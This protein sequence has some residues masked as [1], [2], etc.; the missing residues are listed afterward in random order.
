MAQ[1]RSKQ[2][3]VAKLMTC[4]AL[5][6]V[7]IASL[8]AGCSAAGD[9]SE[10]EVLDRQTEAQIIIDCTRYN[11]PCATYKWSGTKCEPTP[12]L[13]EGAACG[14]TR[15]Y[16]TRGECYFN[17]CCNGCVTFEGKGTPGLCRGDGGVNNGACGALATVCQD[18]TSDACQIPKC[19]GKSCNL[20][21]VDEGGACMGSTGFC[22]RGSCCRG[23][24][25]AEGACAPGN[26]LTACGIAGSE[27]IKCSDCS[28]DKPCTADA[29]VNGK[30]QAP[31]VPPQTSCDDGNICNGTSECS[32]T[33]C[34][35]GTALDCDD[36]DPCTVDTCDPQGGCKHTIEAGLDCND[37]DAC[38]T[39]EKCNAAGAC[40]GGVVNKCDDNKSC[41]TD[42]CEA[43]LCTHT[44]V[45]PG[46]T[47][48][49]GNGCTTT[50]A[51]NDDGECIGTGGPTCDDDNQCTKNACAA[52]ICS[53]PFEPVTTA[54]ISANKCVQ[55]SHCAGTSGTCV[56]G[57]PLDC[58]DDNDCTDD[59]CDPASGCQHVPTT[60]VVECV[61][62]NAC[63]VMDKC[64]A[65]ECVGTPM[66]CLA[67]DACHEPGECE[68]STGRCDDPRSEDGKECPGGAC[69]AG[70][71]DPDATVS[72]GGA[73]S[74]GAAH[75]E[76]GA[77]SGGV[78]IGTGGQPTGDAGEATTP[79]DGGTS[80]EPVERPFVRNPGGC[81][82]QAPG[83]GKVSG[84]LMV[85]GLALA[86]AA[87]RRRS[88]P[89]AQG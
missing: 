4:T 20:Q 15:E 60:Q 54:C 69:A 8:A 14:G 51:C 57:P 34:S 25:D 10:P 29:C 82:C 23:C 86:M 31:A 9:G 48:N 19:D 55:N 56:D 83:K 44:A 58:D 17:T 68:P 77:A 5:L 63:T 32:G 73:D 1:H 37:K 74:G 75:G 12:A 38:T 41:T 62:G 85:A 67:L 43:G 36:R 13:K 65:G 89:R 21:P 64:V 42:K 24:L 61:D 71:C 70:V 80:G 84:A 50:D 52:D 59:S 28:D 66:P 18:C 35:A 11:N 53:H 39:G 7:G 27:P 40:V 78:P 49:D 87:R 47:C 3:G 88:A 30:C 26:T 76:A 79:G 46:T 81:S 6:L 33:T 45:E 2:R 16:P 22:T 72:E